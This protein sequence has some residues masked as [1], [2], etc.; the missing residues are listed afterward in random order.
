[1][2]LNTIAAIG[3]MTM[4]PV[5]PAA[6]ALIATKMTTATT[7]VPLPFLPTK[8]L[9]SNAENS[10]VFSAKPT[11]RIATSTM[12]SGGK[13]VKLVTALEIIC[14]RPATDNRF[15]AVITFFVRGW[16]AEKFAMEPRKDKTS[17][18][19]ARD[20]KMVNGSGSLLPVRSNQSRNFSNMPSGLL[21]GFC[22][23]G[24]TKT[25]P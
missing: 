13:P 14:C 18:I 11:P 8:V 5:S 1:M 2:A 22:S 4:K 17:T 20:A 24:D 21:F 7:M 15:T 16:T 10:P 23:T 3:G 25:P 19:T 9:R 12:P 6:F